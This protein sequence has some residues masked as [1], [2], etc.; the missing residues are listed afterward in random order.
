MGKMVEQVLLEK[1]RT[2]ISIIDS[3]GTHKEIRP[4]LVQEADVCIDFSHPRNVVRTIEQ[5]AEMGKPLV[6]GTTGW[7]EHLPYISKLVEKNQIGLIY[8]PNFSIG[9]HL[10]KQ[11]VAQA[12]ALIDSFDQYDVTLVENHHRQKSDSPSGTALD[13][14]DL[15][16]SKVKRKTT[17]VHELGNRK[18]EPH[19]LQICS[20]RSGHHP[21]KHEVAFDSAQ[22]SIRLIHEARSRLGF[23]LGAVTAADWIAK[24]KG[25]YTLTQMMESIK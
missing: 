1:G 14:A 16:V 3:H 6:V 4:E 13:L 23:A 11:L 9:V 22:D 20:V 18:I 5:L 10:F 8:A 15:L 12:A 19:E 17:S 24:R 2:P 21:G 7:Y 25:L